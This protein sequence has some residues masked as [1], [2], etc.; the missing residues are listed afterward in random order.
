MDESRGGLWA[1]RQ[2]SHLKWLES[3][4]RGLQFAGGFRRHVLRESFGAQC[5]REMQKECVSLAVARAESLASH[6]ITPIPSLCKGG[7]EHGM[8]M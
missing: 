5:R 6:F 2:S 1:T 3:T 7:G 4:R 8:G